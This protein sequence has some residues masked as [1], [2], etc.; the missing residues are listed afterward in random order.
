M[1][2]NNIPAELQPDDEFSI[3]LPS[4][5]NIALS[6]CHPTFQK[7]SGADF[8]FSYGNKPILNYQNKPVFAELVI[9]R[10][11]IDF[12]WE[13]VWV[14]SYGGTHF[15]NEMP[16]GWKLSPK[17][18]KIPED[19]EMI[20]KNIWRTAK[21]T[22]CFDVLAW[23]DD[24]ILLCEAKNSG[25]DRLTKPQ[26]KFIEGAITCGVPISSLLIVEWKLNNI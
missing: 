14:E 1:L 2:D 15:L 20:L 10:M 5:A 4:G 9:A 17:S 7:W 23:K 24:D 11:L 22:A 6:I 26:L 21:T 12:G 19:K 16:N 8:L 3:T 25:K 13:A 18:I